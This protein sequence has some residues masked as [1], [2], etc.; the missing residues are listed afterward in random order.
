M[1]FFRYLIAAL[2]IGAGFTSLPAEA[3]WNNQPYQLP[4][5]GNTFGMSPAYRQV[6]LQRKLNGTPSNPILRD[7]AGNLVDIERRGNLAFLRAQASPF[8]VSS[9]GLGFGA[10]LG[11]DGVS[12]GWGLGGSLGYASGAAGGAISN[13][14]AV[15]ASWTGMLD[16]APTLIG[17]YGFGGPGAVIDSWIGQLSSMPSS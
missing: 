9:S 10:G 2:A 14:G 12:L 8:L 7:G 13:G 1:H 6:I 15:I 4:S 17:A 3:Q 16:G 5:R 11:I